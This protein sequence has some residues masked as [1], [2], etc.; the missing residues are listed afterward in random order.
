MSDWTFDKPSALQKQRDPIQGEFFNT[1]SI[2]NVADSLVRE[3]V[4]N[5]LDAAMDGHRVEVA[6]HVAEFGTPPSG[7]MHQLFGGLRPHLAACD[8]STAQVLD[9]PC[10][11]LVVEDFGTTGLRGDVAQIYAGNGGLPEEFFHF[12]RAE[13]KSS[14]SGADRGS[15]GI[16]KYTFPKASRINTFFGV[17]VQTEPVLG[18]G[19]YSMGQAILRNHAVGDSHFTPDGWWAAI[20]NGVPLPFEAGDPQHELLLSNFRI[21]RR[22]EPGLT[23]IIPYIEDELTPSALV[24][25]I[26]KN[27]GVAILAGEILFRLTSDAEASEMVVDAV[28]VRQLAEKLDGTHDL[29]PDLTMAEWASSATA[30]D[31]GHLQRLDDDVR[32]SGQYPPDLMTPDLRKWVSKRLMLSDQPFGLKVPVRVNDAGRRAAEWAD[33]EVVFLPSE[34]RTGQPRFYRE[35]I[36]IIDAGKNQRTHGAEAMVL[37]G[38]GPLAE[39]LGLAEGPAHTDWSPSTERFKGRYADGKRWISFVRNAPREIL[40]LARSDT[41]EEDRNVAIDF[42]SIKEKPEFER[43]REKRGGDKADKTAEPPEV[44]APPA[45]TRVLKVDGGFAVTAPNCEAGDRV[46]VLAAYDVRRG[47]P[48]K[49]WR[50]FDFTFSPEDGNLQIAVTGGRILEG[51]DNHLTLVVDDPGEFAC[52]VT[53]FDVHRDLV[54]RA[55]RKD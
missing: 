47:N 46:R 26:V 44:S 24:R 9:E 12:F 11:Y 30:A 15:W 41:E 18:A 13:G 55:R 29:L 8:S 40:R 20:R 39:M 25:A 49:K 48:Y 21:R 43:P 19:P 54:V 1:D 34:G 2:E 16:G 3:F 4:Q 28:N 5:S 53:G 7:E 31:W 33:M 37:I 50:E 22:D 17:T 10:R 14:K 51:E 32:P 6:F 36:R 42:F 27:Y 38:R 52:T 23:I 35:G 45:R